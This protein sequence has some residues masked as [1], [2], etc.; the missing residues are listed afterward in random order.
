MLPFFL[1]ILTEIRVPAE[2]FSV[3]SENILPSLKSG[4]SSVTNSLFQKHNSLQDNK[5]RQIQF[6]KATFFRKDSQLKV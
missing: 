5:H 4:S 2:L 6:T 3:N 1:K